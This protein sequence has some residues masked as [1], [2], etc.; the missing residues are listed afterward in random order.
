MRFKTTTE[1]GVRPLIHEIL[2]KWADGLSPRAHRSKLKD[3]VSIPIHLQQQALIFVNAFNKLVGIEMPQ[4]SRQVIT[5]LHAQTEQSQGQSPTL[6]AS[7]RQLAPPIHSPSSKKD[8]LHVS[9]TR[10]GLKLHNFVPCRFLRIQSHF[11][12]AAVSPQLPA[13]QIFLRYALTDSSLT[14]TGQG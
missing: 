11:G 2:C 4:L 14:W 7:S 9:H 1:I 3:Q 10:H 6:P 13:M 12:A 8:H 5:L